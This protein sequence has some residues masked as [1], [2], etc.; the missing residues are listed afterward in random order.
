MSSALIEKSLHL[1]DGQKIGYI[2]TGEGSRT[3]LFLPGALGTAKSDFL[4]QLTGL[5]PAT[6]PQILIKV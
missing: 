2:Q 4:P 5:E 1:N 6:F 3:V